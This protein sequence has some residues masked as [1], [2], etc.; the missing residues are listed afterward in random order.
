MKATSIKRIIKV[1][2]TGKVPDNAKFLYSKEET[3]YSRPRY[4]SRQGLF[5][6]TDYTR[7]PYTKVTHYY[8]VNE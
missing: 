6:T 4:T 8:E 3:D 7:Y 1:E 2:E 5:I